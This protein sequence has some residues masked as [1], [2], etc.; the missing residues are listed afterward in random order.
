MPD[1][2]DVIL[3]EMTKV[4]IMF[5]LPRITLNTKTKEVSVEY[6]WQNDDAKRNYELL[7][8]M[9][10]IENVALLEQQYAQ[11]RVHL[12]AAGGESAGDGNNSGGR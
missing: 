9:L 11:H 5:C 4:Y 3:Q 2:R 1:K 6:I 12:T 7:G 8:E 10:K